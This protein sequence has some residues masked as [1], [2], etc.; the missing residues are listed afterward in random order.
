MSNVVFCFQ[1][2]KVT[3]IP[4]DTCVMEGGKES[5]SMFNVMKIIF[6]SPQ[7]KW[8]ERSRGVNFKVAQNE[9]EKEKVT[10]LLCG[11]EQERASHH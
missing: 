11:A 7:R 1:E 4:V 8:C 3:H 2:T 10:H 9:V 6:V 5:P